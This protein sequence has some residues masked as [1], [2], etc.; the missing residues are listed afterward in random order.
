MD[1]DWRVPMMVNL[2][3]KPSPLFISTTEEE[4]NDFNWH[5]KTGL[6]RNI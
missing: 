4:D 5:C 6:R 1:S 3:M 2:W